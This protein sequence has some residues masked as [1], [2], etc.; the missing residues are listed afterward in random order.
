L[1]I[2]DRYID[3]AVDT[4]CNYICPI[5][6]NAKQMVIQKL[7]GRIKDQATK[8]KDEKLIQDFIKPII[9]WIWFVTYKISVNNK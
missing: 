4:E 1:R 8:N 5:Q 3:L 6:T 7:F 2:S 9:T